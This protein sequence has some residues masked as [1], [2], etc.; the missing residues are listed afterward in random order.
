MSDN[1]RFL[2]WQEILDQLLSLL[3]PQ[4]RANFTGKV[5]KR[6]LVAIALS[7][8]ALYGLLAKVL[9]LAI[10]E[11][12]EGRWLRAVVAGLGMSAYSGIK[13]TAIARFERWGSTATRIK[14]PAGTT[15]QATNGLTFLT[16]AEAVL[17]VGEATVLVPCTCS[18]EGVLGNVAAGQ[19]VALKTALLGIDAVSNPDPAVG[20]ADAESDG[21]IKA[22]VPQHLAMLHRATIPAT[23]AAIAARPDLFPEVLAFLTELRAGLPGYVRGVLSDTSGGDL[24]RPAAWQA[25]ELAGVWFA[26]VA[27]VPYGLILVGWPCQRFGVVKRDSTG[28]ER[29]DASESALAVSQGAYRW[30]YDANQ[31]RLYASADGRDLNELDLVVYAGVLWRALRELEQRWIAAGVQ[32]DIIAPIPI[33]VPITLE[34]ALEPG[35][36]AATVESALR[37]AVSTVINAL[38]MGSTLELETLYGRLNGAAG[39]GGVV[40]LTPVSNVSVAGNEI[41]RAGAITIT[42]RG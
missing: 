20:G 33:R 13:A 14:I 30:F 42:R 23:E 39:A 38:P 28:A 1:I 9:R 34:Y 40:V 16:D 3:P 5:L 10:L 31:N 11:T 8:E 7:L 4:W 19:I 25:T 24:F 26:V 21:S 2:S 17:Q 32:I 29:W 37:E 18:R 36:V 12:S 15:V 27:Q 6:L 35:Y 41:V 22:R